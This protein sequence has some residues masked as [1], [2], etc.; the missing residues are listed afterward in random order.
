[1]V[2]PTNLKDWQYRNS[3]LTY[4]HKKAGFFLS[5]S[6][7]VTFAVAGGGHRKYIRDS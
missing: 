7:F 5:L 1:M 2:N 6:I 3:F 4:R